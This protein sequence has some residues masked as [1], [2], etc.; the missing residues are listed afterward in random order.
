MPG[1]TEYS[2]DAAFPRSYH[3]PFVGTSDDINALHTNG[4]SRLSVAARGGDPQKVYD[5]LQ[6]G[7]VV[8]PMAEPEFGFQVP[9]FEAAASG[10]PRV[11]RMLLDAGADPNFGPPGDS[12][13]AHVVDMESFEMLLAAGATPQEVLAHDRFIPDEI[14]ENDAIPVAE[15]VRLLRA[16][17]NA[18]ADLDRVNSIGTP[19]LFRAGMRGDPDAVQ[20]LFEAGADPTVAPTAL[21][22]V[23][24]SFCDALD[25]GMERVVDLCVAA[26]L[27]V[28]EADEN[29]YTPLHCALSPDWYGPGYSESDGANVAV[30]VALMRHGA[31]VDVPYPGTYEG[32]LPLHVAAEQKLIP[33]I[34]ALIATGADKSARNPSGDTYLDILRRR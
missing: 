6:A 32:W 14:A 21:Q 22:G 7:A 17:N 23:C 3:C 10:D 25:A 2:G 9:L 13:L 31:R 34:E 28:N 20:A 27:D 24:F 1:R 26:G 5:L 29:G 16:L 18:G 33:V 8:Q 30:A 15:R 12:V 19:A 4:M 11:V